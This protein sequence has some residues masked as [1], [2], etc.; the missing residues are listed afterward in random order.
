M[1][2]ILG[3]WLRLLFKCRRLPT[4]GVLVKYINIGAQGLKSDLRAGQIRHS[5][6]YSSLS[7]F[8]GFLGVEAVLHGH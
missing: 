2:N 3:Y 7:S 8:R 5:V 6:A 1:F 4:H